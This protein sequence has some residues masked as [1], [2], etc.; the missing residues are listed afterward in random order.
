MKIIAKFQKRILVLWKPLSDPTKLKS[1]SNLNGFDA[2]F[3]LCC[4]ND[5]A[6]LP[7]EH[8]KSEMGALFRHLE[9]GYSGQI[10]SVEN[11]IREREERAKNLSSIGRLLNELD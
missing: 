4:T 5:V 10:A 9:A 6:L 11:S 8:N 1:A 2:I 7:I 3:Q